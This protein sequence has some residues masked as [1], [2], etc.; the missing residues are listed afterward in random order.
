VVALLSPKDAEEIYTLRAVLESLAARL[1]VE[2]GRVDA[3]AL[4]E[5]NGH[6]DEIA[7]TGAAADLRGLA[8]ADMSFHSA[9]SALSGHDLL[10]EHL[11]AIRHHSL[12]LLFH[13]GLYRPDV[14]AV[15]RRHHRLLDVLR[16]GDPAVVAMA[17]E[18]HVI[19]PGKLI[20]ERMRTSGGAD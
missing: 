7:R 2:R 20:V 12:R 3:A 5:L 9:L 13:G 14:A 15:V 6:V 4:D 1:A 11:D 16:A 18:D 8:Y 17:I 19:S 10:I